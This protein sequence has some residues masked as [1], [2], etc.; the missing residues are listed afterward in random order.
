MSGP[1]KTCKVCSTLALRVMEQ[2]PESKAFKDENSSELPADYEGEGVA[3]LN[4]ASSLP[5]DR[6]D[7]GWRFY[8]SFTSLCII[9]LAVALDALSLSAAL[10]V[11]LPSLAAE[12]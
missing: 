12:A 6:F 8:T 5:P 2:L 11:I 10:P 1:K 3:V 9:T 7:P 4:L